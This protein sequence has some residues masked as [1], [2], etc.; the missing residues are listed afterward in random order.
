M[1]EVIDKYYRTYP[2]HAR[3]AADMEHRIPDWIN[4]QAEEHQTFNLWGQFLLE[5]Y[6]AY[7]ALRIALGTG[8]FKLRL[9]AIRRLAPVFCG[10]GKDRYQWIASV[11]LADMARMTDDDFKALS[12]LFSTS[13]GGDAFARVG[14]DEKQEVV[15]RL[16]KGAVM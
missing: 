2:R 16:Y 6:P 13:L 5:D 1:T 9:A 7:L 4:A 14:L 10:Y 15:N 11:H 3:Q 8:D 12:Y